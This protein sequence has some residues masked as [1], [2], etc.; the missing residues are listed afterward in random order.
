MM[1]ERIKTKPGYKLLSIMFLLF[2]FFYMMDATSLTV[3][4]NEYNEI[5]A[6]DGVSCTPTYSLSLLEDAER[7]IRD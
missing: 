3:T 4:V 2:S 6:V 7:I 1:L 5:I